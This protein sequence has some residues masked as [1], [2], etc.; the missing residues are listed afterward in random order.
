VHIEEVINNL[1]P[2]EVICCVSDLPHPVKGAEVVVATSSDNYNKLKLSLQLKLELP[3]IAIPKHYY[4]I[5]EMPISG[6]GK[7]DFRKVRQ[8]C[9]K[10][11]ENQKKNKED[12]KSKI[13]SFVQKKSDKKHSTTEDTEPQ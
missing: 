8:I 2:E 9:L 1:L 7:I 10:L 13:S 12:F 11:R 4:V 5:E 3:A 6:T